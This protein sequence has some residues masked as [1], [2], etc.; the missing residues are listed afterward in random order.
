MPQSRVAESDRDLIG[1]LH[2]IPD[3]GMRCGIRIQGWFLLL[4]LVLGILSSCQSFRDLPQYS[5][6]RRLG[7][8]QPPPQGSD[9]FPGD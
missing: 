1:I 4:V 9:Q 3:A 8:R 5:R 6:R 2:A 7:L